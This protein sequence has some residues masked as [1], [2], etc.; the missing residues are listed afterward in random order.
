[1]PKS[2]LSALLSLLLV[3]LSGAVLGA[4]AY[5]LYMVNTVSSSAGTRRPSVQEFR[6]FYVQDLNKHASL[7][8]QQIAQVN[9]ILDQIGAETNQKMTAIHEEQIA[10]INAILRPEQQAAYQKMRDEHDAERRR[11]KQQQEATKK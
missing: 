4:F 11:R 1:M 3:F 6:K 10:R 7:D 2:K 5:R 8:S 9:A